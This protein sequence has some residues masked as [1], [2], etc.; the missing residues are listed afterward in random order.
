MIRNKNFSE[1]NLSSFKFIPINLL[2]KVFLVSDKYFGYPGKWN[3]L[4]PVLAPSYGDADIGDARSST[5]GT[6]GS[7]HREEPKKFQKLN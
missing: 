4:E 6:L 5:M 3:N 7:L 1:K 2:T